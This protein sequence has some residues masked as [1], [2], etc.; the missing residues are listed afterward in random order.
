MPIR[1][2]TFFFRGKRR[3]WI[4]AEVVRSWSSR[5]SLSQHEI[6]LERTCLTDCAQREVFVHVLRAKV[7]GIGNNTV[8]LANCQRSRKVLLQ[9]AQIFGK[10][11]KNNLTIA[12]ASQNAAVVFL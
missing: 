3:N 6:R 7:D 12:K 2:R 8:L 4:K 10:N 5:T 1:M 11:S 9:I